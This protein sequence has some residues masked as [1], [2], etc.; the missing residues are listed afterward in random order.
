MAIV[1]EVHVG[2]IG[3]IFR[4]TLHDNGVALDVS[5]ASTLEF[6]FQKPN[7]TTLTKTAV[8]TGDGTDGVVEYTTV[9]GDIDLHG[10]WKI[11]AYVV[12]PSGN[13]RSSIVEFKVYENL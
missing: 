3:T 9:S 4:A 2:D 6:T 1:E 11:Q 7:G 8:L 12:L 13:W 5:S 10:D